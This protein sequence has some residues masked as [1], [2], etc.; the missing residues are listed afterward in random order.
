M[1]R[2]SRLF[3]VFILCGL[4]LIMIFSLS[5]CVDQHT[6]NAE[7]TNKYS[8]PDIAEGDTFEIIVKGEGQYVWHYSIEPG[9][10]I[11]YVSREGVGEH[12]D[13]PDWAGGWPWR[14]TFK[15]LKAGNYKIKFEYSLAWTDAP[16]IETNVYNIKVVKSN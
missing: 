3:N 7:N 5:A 16:P 1:A 11:E 9:T 6:N 14:Y 12:V 2:K 13:D 4:T 10:G 8:L 15:A